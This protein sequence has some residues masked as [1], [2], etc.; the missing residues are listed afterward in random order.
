MISSYYVFKL[1]KL[2][3]KNH[4]NWIENESKDVTNS[5]NNDIKAYNHWI[6]S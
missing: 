4:E 6:F 1:Q 2:A 3:I 5:H